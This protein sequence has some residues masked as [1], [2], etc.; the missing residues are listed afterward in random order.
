[1]DVEAR[2]PRVFLNS[3]FYEKSGAFSPNGR[4]LAYVSDESG[5][6]EVYVQSF[7]APGLKRLVSSGGGEEPAWAPSGRELYYRNGGRMMAVAVNEEP[8][9]TASRPETLFEGLYQ[10]APFPTRTYD[11]DPDGGFVMVAEPGP[12][13]STRRLIVVL[14]WASELEQA[15][16]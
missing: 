8:E 6:Y 12:E 9:F 5:Q 4:W 14:N 11:V 15:N 1:M 13:E 16:R 2:E 10:Y 3:D 7:P